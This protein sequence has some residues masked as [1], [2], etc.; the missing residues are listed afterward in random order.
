MSPKA[1]VVLIALLVLAVA[2]AG[3]IA[4]ALRW[5]VASA[6]ELPLRLRVEDGTG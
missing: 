5:V 6:I 3:W 1:W 2:V 4:S